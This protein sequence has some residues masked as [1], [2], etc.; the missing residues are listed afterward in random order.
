MFPKSTIPASPVSSQALLIPQAILH[1]QSQQSERGI[2]LF[3]I[4]AIICAMLLA[5]AK[6]ASAQ[7]NLNFSN[8]QVVKVTKAVG[9][10]NVKHLYT[11]N[12]FG[13]TCISTIK[14]QY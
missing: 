3:L 10:L 5:L 1:H 12:M 11:V 8:N 6:P 4:T 9:S 14:V 13:Y 2:R 7:P